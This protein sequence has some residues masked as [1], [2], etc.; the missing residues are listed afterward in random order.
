MKC[1]SHKHKGEAV[2]VED[3]QRQGRPYLFAYCGLRVTLGL[4]GN[5]TT[6]LDNSKQ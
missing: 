5:L 2:Q 1:F 4:L 6:G 3:R